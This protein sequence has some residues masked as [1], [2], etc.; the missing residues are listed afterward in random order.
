MKHHLSS[1]LLLKSI[2]TICSMN[3]AA[4][5]GTATGRLEGCRV[6]DSEVNGAFPLRLETRE[7][8]KNRLSHNH[9]FADYSTTL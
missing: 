4:R 3:G 7:Q 5:C 8:G 1:D 6:L 2:P 9:E